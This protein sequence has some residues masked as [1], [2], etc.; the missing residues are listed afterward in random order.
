[1]F[2]AHTPKTC[3]AKDTS[4]NYHVASR[5]HFTL[6]HDEDARPNNPQITDILH[7]VQ[8]TFLTISRSFFLRMRNVPDTI[9]TENRKT[10]A[11]FYNFFEN[12]AVYE[13]L[14]KNTV[15]PDRSQM[16]IWRMYIA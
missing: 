4:I 9:C 16:T 5:W 11:I 2:W 12:C 8:Y 10:D 14:Y 6:F 15:Q 3:R 13:I 7:E 1:M